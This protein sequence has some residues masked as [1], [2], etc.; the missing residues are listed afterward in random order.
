MKKLLGILIIIA[1][2][3]VCFIHFSQGE[4][5]EIA[6]N[7][8]PVIKIGAT[9]PLSGDASQF[10]LTSKKALELAVNTWNQKD[11]KYKYEL[12]VEDDRGVQKNTLINAKNLI[13]VKK[14]NAIITQ[15]T[16]F[17]VIVSPLADEA[18]IIH[19]TCSFGDEVVKGKYNFNHYTSFKEQANT[20]IKSFNDRNVKN[21]NYVVVNTAGC[22]EQA[23][24]VI[25]EIKKTNINV[26][27]VSYYNPSER[28]FRMLIRKLETSNPDYYMLCGAPPSA[29][30][31]IKQLG[32][33]TGKKNITSIDTFIELN[34]EDLPLVEG[35][36]FV[37]SASGTDTFAKFFSDNAGMEITSC[38]ANVYDAIDFII[39]AYENTP[40]KE[41]EVIPDT[42]SV[43]NTLH[44]IKG[45]DSAVGNIEIDENGVV[46]SK[47]SVKIIKDGQIIGE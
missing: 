12:F 29:Q 17:G 24:F 23:S 18:G 45:Y 16:P 38:T 20:L 44:K 31:F 9:L 28:D 10:G 42:D 25:N 14:V 34:K 47:A 7:S 35:L 2:V 22:E 5:S 26:A 19:F 21:I 4:K 8:K 1:V 32:E 11:T 30:I 36:W 40:L 33:I 39:Y 15:W 13:N 43:A 27:N 41:G 3:A 6:D 37:N 46:V